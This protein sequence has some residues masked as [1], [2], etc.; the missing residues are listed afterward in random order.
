[1]NVQFFK[2]L[3]NHK[4]NR[5]ISHYIMDKLQNKAAG[6]SKFLEIK[7]DKAII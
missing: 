3:V 4:N 2:N 1:M 6:H 7:A 5:I